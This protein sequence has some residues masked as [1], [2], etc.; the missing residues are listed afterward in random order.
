[1]D[2]REVN[3]DSLIATNPNFYQAYQLAG[4]ELFREKKFADALHYYRLALSKEIATKNEQNEIRN[5]VSI[6]EEKMK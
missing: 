4:N 1:M 3:P 2:G 5:Q 6:C